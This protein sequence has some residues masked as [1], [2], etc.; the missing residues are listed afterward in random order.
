M[1]INSLQTVNYV[2][3]KY[4]HSHAGVNSAENKRGIWVW[5]EK[6]EFSRARVSRKKVSPGRYGGNIA[7]FSAL[8]MNTKI[9][10]VIFPHFFS[11]FFSLRD[12]VYFGIH[13]N[14]YYPWLFSNNPSV[15]VSNDHD[16]HWRSLKIIERLLKGHLRSLKIIEDHWRSLKNIEEH[17]RSWKVIEGH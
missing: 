3:A 2:I 4:L 7:F 6:M 15:V 12:Y 13:D 17:W 5:K 10:N 8:L 1:S 14:D 16:D 9:Q 11:E